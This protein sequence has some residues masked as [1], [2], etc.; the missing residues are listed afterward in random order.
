MFVPS[1]KYMA[2][3]SSDMTASCASTICEL[4]VKNQ[5]LISRSLDLGLVAQAIELRRIDSHLIRLLC[6]VRGFDFVA[7]V[8]KGKTLLVGEGNL[9]FSLSLAKKQRIIPTNILASTYEKERELS[10]EAKANAAAL[11]RRGAKVI[12][13]VDSAKI[14]GIFSG[15]KFETI[16]F[17][18]PHTGSREPING[19][20][21]NFILVRDFLRS[22][23]RL[24]THSGV[25]LIS[26]VDSPHYRGAFQFEEAAKE[27][28]FSEPE[29]YPFKPDVS[30]G[31]FIR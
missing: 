10:P 4:G 14:A 2:H 3:S 20:N 7:Q 17:Q 8:A 19:R 24:L 28:G 1:S 16:I 30:Q 5:W 27:A 29:S 21:P 22:A 6:K 13:G 15:Q 31:M 25:V 12:H 11:T 26:T 9:S 18:F 23:G